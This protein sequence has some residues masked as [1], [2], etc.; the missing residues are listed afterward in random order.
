MPGE[1]HA[2]IRAIWGTIGFEAVDLHFLLIDMDAN[3]PFDFYLDQEATNG[4]I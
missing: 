1:V 2:A 3:E 4:R